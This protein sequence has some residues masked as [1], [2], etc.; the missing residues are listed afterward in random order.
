MNTP[1]RPTALPT[2][3]FTGQTR[4]GDIDLIWEEVPMR[5]KD[6]DAFRSGEPIMH[7]C[8]EYAAAEIEV[9]RGVRSSDNRVVAVAFL[10]PKEAWVP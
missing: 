6:V 8:P 5:Y 10:S 7:L 3:R 1:K 2:Q 9:H 4:V